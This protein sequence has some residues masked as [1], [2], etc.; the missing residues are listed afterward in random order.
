MFQLN[1]SGQSPQSHSAA[2]LTSAAVLAAALDAL[3]LP[4]IIVD[5]EMHVLHAN[6]AA[7]GLT[8]PGRSGL[9]VS[10]AG[11]G[12]THLRAHHRDDNAAL[13]RL[14]AKAAGGEPGGAV[15]VRRHHDDCLEEATLAVQVGPA[16]T[17]LTMGKEPVKA[18]AMISARE[19]ARPSR[20]EAAILSDL[21]GLTRAEADVAGALAGGITAEE[22][23]H[24]R[25]V[26]LDTIRAQVRTVLRKTN[27]ANLRD[28]ERIVA[29]VSA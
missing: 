12:G 17:H 5:A 20:G 23:A 28:L 11:A 25:Q 14:V 19:L 29:L 22:V 16:S 21:Y 8:A 13:R 9:I 1:E 27:A 26:S 24:A 2:T 10:R 4:L 7:D 18:V 6:A 3:P 15:R